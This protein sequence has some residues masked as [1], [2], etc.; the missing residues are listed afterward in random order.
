VVCHHSL[1]S[2]AHT[3][4]ACTYIHMGRIVFLFRVPTLQRYLGTLA[5][6]VYCTLESSCTVPAVAGTMPYIVLSC[7]LCNTLCNTICNTPPR[8]GARHGTYLYG[9][10][11][12]RTALDR[13]VLARKCD[14][15]RAGLW[16]GAAAA[17]S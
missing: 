6:F 4:M 12:W 11:L 16:V 9:R 5:P 13:T 15:T 10:H 1:A 14:A 17:F 8:Y 2:T 3:Y 7:T